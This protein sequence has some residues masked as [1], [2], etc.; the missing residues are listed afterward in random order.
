VNVFSLSSTIPRVQELLSNNAASGIGE[1]N[2]YCLPEK[3]LKN[4]LS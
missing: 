3:G 1:K 4:Y 2:E